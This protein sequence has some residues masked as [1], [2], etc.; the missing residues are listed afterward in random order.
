MPGSCRSEGLA[1]FELYAGADPLADHLLDA[2]E[3]QAGERATAERDENASTELL[4][5][6]GLAIAIAVRS[7]QPPQRI[8]DRIKIRLAVNTDMQMHAII[9]LAPLPTR[10][11]C[12]LPLHG[13][14]YTV[15]CIGTPTR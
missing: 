12:P 10:Y 15:S 1:T 4:V 5:R 14:I 9:V 2:V 13:L 11:H 8:A 3:E 6:L 7:E